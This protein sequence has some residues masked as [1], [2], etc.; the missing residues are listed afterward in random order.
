MGDLI[1]DFDTF[2]DSANDISGPG[3]VAPHWLAA[4]EE[5][6]IP[7]DTDVFEDFRPHRSLDD[8]SPHRS[9]RQCL[10]HLTPS[11]NSTVVWARRRVG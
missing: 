5:Q 1:G 9:S 8:Q 3:D 7:V 4:S 2:R 11:S 6:G 10:P